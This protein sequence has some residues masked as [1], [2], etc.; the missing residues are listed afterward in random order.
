MSCGQ[1]WAPFQTPQTVSLT[2]DGFTGLDT[3]RLP[4]DVNASVNASVRTALSD[5]P[6]NANQLA[7]ELNVGYRT[8]RHH[9]ELLEEHDVVEGGDNDY[10]KLYFLTDRFETYRDTFEQI[11]EHVD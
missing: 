3:V 10:G 1:L 6:M 7:T 8:I 9:I 11:T 5:R 4:S 2:D